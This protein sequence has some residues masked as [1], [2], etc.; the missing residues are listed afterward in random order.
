MEILIGCGFFV[1]YLVEVLAIYMCG[2]DHIDYN[3]NRIE[4]NH[5]KNE[6]NV[7]E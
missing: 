6:K 4:C 2:Q 7:T 5:C 3:V 1:V